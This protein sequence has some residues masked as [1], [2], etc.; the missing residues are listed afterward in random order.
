M[1]LKIRIIINTPNEQI[2]FGDLKEIAHSETLEKLAEHFAT[3]EKTL[4]ERAAEHLL[5][6]TVGSEQASGYRISFVQKEE[7]LPDVG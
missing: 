1:D 2:S 6:E 4:K 3:W 5:I 7:S